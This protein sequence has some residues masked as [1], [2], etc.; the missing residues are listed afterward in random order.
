[1]VTVPDRLKGATELMDLPGVD[2][3]ELAHTLKDLAWINRVLGS[4]RLVRRHL[5]PLIPHLPRAIRILDV[6]TG[7]ADIPRAIVQWARQRDVPIEIEGVDHHDQIL[8]LA[9][10][11]SAAFPEIRLRRGNA[12]SLPYPD[13]SFDVVLASLILHHMEGE[14]QVRLL[15]ELYRIARRAV[16][17]NDLRRGYWPFLVTWASLH[18]VSRSRLIHHDGPVSVR[19]GFLVEE[20]QALAQEAGW[21]RVQVSRNPFFRLALVGEKS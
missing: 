18:V 13:E 4:V 7:Y 8:A 2:L 20:L 1:M 16:L 6:G 3:G 15:Q 19:R 12:S 10:H 5:A 11:A 14:E 9:R 21:K 17:V